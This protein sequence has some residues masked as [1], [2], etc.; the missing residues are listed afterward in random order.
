MRIAVLACDALRKEIDHFVDGDEDIV[1]KEY[2]EFGLHLHPDEL[3]A[4]IEERLR[5]LVGKVDAVFLGYGHCQSLQGIA[6]AAPLPTVMLETEDCIAALLT[7][8]RYH[9]EKRNGGI[10]WF[11]PA[12]WAVNGTPGIIRLF[13]LDSVEE[14]PPE[15]FLKI[16]FDGFSR[17]LFIDTGMPGAEEC[18]ACSRDLARTLELRHERCSGSL[19]M[20]EEAIARTK[21]VARAVSGGA[22]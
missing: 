3:K 10:T 6:Q 18:E 8:E 15:Y 2:L 13:H 11:Y 4:V 14:Y 20:I 9:A 22:P 17:C 12:G 19:A 7:T 21:A 16:M 1:H 5:G